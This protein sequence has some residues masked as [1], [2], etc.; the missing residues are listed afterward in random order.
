MPPMLAKHFVASVIGPRHHYFHYYKKYHAATGCFILCRV[1][2]RSSAGYLLL[3]L[4]MLISWAFAQRLILRLG[5]GW[6]EALLS[7]ERYTFAFSAPIYFAREQPPFLSVS[8][9]LFA[10]PTHYDGRY[11][12]IRDISATT[13]IDCFLFRHIS[14]RRCLSPFYSRAARV[15]SPLSLRNRLDSRRTFPRPQ[16]VSISR[17]FST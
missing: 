16:P 17:C 3:R 13:S 5:M 1:S 10:G 12:D 8:L 7:Y 15:Y 2:L 9:T 6:L 4:M 11:F 14:L